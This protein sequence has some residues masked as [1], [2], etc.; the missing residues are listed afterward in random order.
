MVNDE[1][2]SIRERT[3]EIR[4]LNRELDGE[5]ADLRERLNLMDRKRDRDAERQRREIESMAMQFSN[6]REMSVK[7]WFAIISL[8][9]ASLV[10][11][12]PDIFSKA[13]SSKPKQI[14]TQ[15][16]KKK[17]VHNVPYDPWKDTEVDW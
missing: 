6:H 15:E 14:Q 8:A 13:S 12:L 5:L 2:Q 17:D 10:W 9:I 1:A 11:Y 4:R 16:Q 3:E 7:I